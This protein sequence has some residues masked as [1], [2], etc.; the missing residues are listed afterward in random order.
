VSQENVEIVRRFENLM[1]DEE[2]RDAARAAGRAFDEDRMQQVLELLSEDVAFRPFPGMP[3]HGG[4]WIGRDGYLEMCEAYGSAWE[5]AENLELEYLD[6]GGDKVVILISFDSRSKIT[7]E[8]VPVR[9]VEIITVRDGRITELVPYYHDGHRIVETG[10][11]PKQP[12]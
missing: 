7:G 5:P 4:D 8:T 9:M 3:G 11:G 10:G 1:A 12:W 6:G 2:A